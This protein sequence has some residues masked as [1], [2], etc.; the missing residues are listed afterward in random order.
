MA[1]I[2]ALSVQPGV[3]ATP[4]ADQYA[5][6][7]KIGEFSLPGKLNC[8]VSDLN[9]IFSKLP[10]YTT[11]LQSDGIDLIKV[12]S[13]NIAKK[14][15]LFHIIKIRPNGIDVA[16]SII[17][18]SSVELRRANVLSNVAAIL[19]ILSDK[20]SVDYGKFIQYVDSVLEGLVS[21][22]S[23]N[24]TSLYNKYDSIL[25]EYREIKR[26]NIELSASNRNLALQSAQLSEENKSLKAR[27]SE[28]E[29]F[30]DESLMALVEEWIKSH[31]DSIDIVE[32]AKTHNVTPTRIEQ[33]LDKMASMGYIELKG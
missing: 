25:S 29:K 9:E 8:P 6:Q 28:L 20:Y 27:L 5:Q 12:E 33:I 26:Q 30:S 1:D 32:F 3:Q 17:P 22:L 31:N 21:G 16:F 10:L 14:P 2:S 11:K 15:Y 13:R 23:Q 4:S 7:P 18:D 24:Y 19:S